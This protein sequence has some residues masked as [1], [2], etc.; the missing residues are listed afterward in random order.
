MPAATKPP[1]RRVTEP[2]A[3]GEPRRA[4]SARLPCRRL[5]QGLRWR[6]WQAR[7]CPPLRNAGG[8][9]GDRALRFLLNGWTLA[10]VT[11]FCAEC[12]LWR[13][14][15]CATT[16][17]RW[18]RDPQQCCQH[19]AESLGATP[20]TASAP[21]GFSEGIQGSVKLSHARAG[22]PDHSVA[23]AGRCGRRFYLGPV[24]TTKRRVYSGH[25]VPPPRRRCAPWSAA[26][27][28]SPDLPS[29]SVSLTPC[30]SHAVT[31][32]DTNQGCGAPKNAPSMLPGPGRRGASLSRAS[33][34][35]SSAFT[36]Q[37]R[38]SRDEFVYRAVILSLKVL[39]RTRFSQKC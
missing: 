25:R 4:G 23:C 36:P 18:L 39:Q 30:M 2:L 11:P 22:F 29:Q 34:R 15:A 5:P 38:S 20:S 14:P 3:H 35:W 12:A 13:P 1:H 8:G 37:A 17:R 28:G 26:A 33:S 7:C 32:G 24:Q 10:R 16:F 21:E 9:F 6:R 27:A 31:H 19:V